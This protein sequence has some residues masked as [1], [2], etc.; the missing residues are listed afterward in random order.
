MFESRFVPVVCLGAALAACGGDGGTTEPP[1][2]PPVATV[3]VTGPGSQAVPL[4]E[5][6][7]VV[8]L[9]DASGAEL[10]DREIAWSSSRE[11]VAT[12]SASGLVTAVAPGSA[13][14]T[15]TSEGKSGGLALTVNEGGL[16]G[17]DGAT[18]AALGGSVVLEVP[19]GAVSS[20]VAITVARAF[21]LPRD[22][23]LLVSSGYVLGPSATSFAQPA[24]ITLR[25]SPGEAPSGVAEADLLVHRIEAGSLASLGGAADA[26]ADAATAPVTA[27]GTFAVARA[28]A[29]TPCTEPEHRQFD[30]W[31]GEWNVTVPGGSSV[32]SDI[33]LEPGGCAVFENFAQGAGRSINV[34]NPGDGQ[35]HQTFVFSNGQRLVLI[36]GLEGDAMVLSRR[37]PGAPTGSFD[38]WTWTQLSEGRVRQL[39]EVSTDGGVTVTTGFDGTYVPR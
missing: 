35:W 32:P 31:V 38:R 10:E 21:G 39:Q 37:F 12:V 30:F 5:L 8:T 13:T 1:P 9:R 26:G 36:G 15:A 7:L 14:I 33:T 11:T 23:S 4:Q 16:V 18:V 25:Y 19:A 28:P 29:E 34:Y 6:Q 17:P 3:T 22:P 2:P 20:P 24:E 27:L